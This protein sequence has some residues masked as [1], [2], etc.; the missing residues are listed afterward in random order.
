MKKRESLVN[1]AVIIEPGIKVM[2]DITFG[3]FDLVYWLVAFAVAYYVAFV[4]DIRKLFSKTKKEEFAAMKPIGKLFPLTIDIS[5][6]EQLTDL[7]T[8]I[9]FKKSLQ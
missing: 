4:I 9:G 8:V 7:L 1:W 3:W 5:C 6:K 2:A